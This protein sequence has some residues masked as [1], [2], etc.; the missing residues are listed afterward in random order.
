MIAYWNALE[1][2]LSHDQ[3]AG[4]D[5]QNQFRFRQDPFSAFALDGRC[6]IRGGTSDAVTKGSAYGSASFIVIPI[7]DPGYRSR[8]GDLHLCGVVSDAGHFVDAAG[9]YSNVD[10]WRYVLSSKPQYA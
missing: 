7:V 3:D 8:C 6:K 2:D 5:R 4:T 10:T 1:A 9:G